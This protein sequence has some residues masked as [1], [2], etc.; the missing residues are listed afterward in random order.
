MH[1]KTEEGD[2]RLNFI[3]GLNKKMLPEDGRRR[4]ESG[5]AP[6]PFIR[7]IEPSEN[8]SSRRSNDGSSLSSRDSAISLDAAKSTAP[9]LS[10]SQLHKQRWPEGGEFLTL[11]FSPSR[12]SVHKLVDFL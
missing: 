11:D 4:V 2:E 8:R 6:S 12:E 5:A 3:L 9:K 10:P 7:A 1:A